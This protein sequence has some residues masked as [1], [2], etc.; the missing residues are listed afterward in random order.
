MTLSFW[1]RLHHSV[2]ACP[3]ALGLVPSLHASAA[4]DPA[5]SADASADWAFKRDDGSSKP[6]PESAPPAERLSFKDGQARAASENRVLLVLVHGSDWNLRGEA[7]MD[8]FWTTAEFVHATGCVVADVDVLETEGSPA[9]ES[10]AIRN[11]GW[12]EKESGL[13]TFPAVLAFGPK[14]TL[15]GTR[16]GQEL[17][18][19]LEGAR[20]ASLKLAQACH[21][22][23][24]LDGELAVA[25]EQG[26]PVRE[27]ALVIERDALPLI[28]KSD[29]QE[30]LKRLDPEDSQGHQVRLTLPS[31][32]SLVQAATQEAQSG[33]P[34][35]AEHRLLGLLSNPAYTP[36]QRAS[37]HL[38]LGSVYRRWEGH[39]AP[40]SE[41]FLAAWRCS[42]ASV[43]GRAGRRLH[44]RHYSGPSLTLGWVERHTASSGEWTV[45][46]LPVELEPGEYT[47]AFRCTRG[48]GPALSAASLRSSSGEI[49]EAWVPEASQGDSQGDSKG[50]EFRFQVDQPIH[51]ASLHIQCTSG[52][53]SRGELTFS[54]VR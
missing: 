12:I 24:Q 42:P 41:Q 4:S 17:P 6:R 27:L 39:G 32:V 23:M 50:G 40:A 45:E 34:Q 53:G 8:G 26:D 21:T 15:L 22:A 11:V 1:G 30:S 20:L 7:F 18:A 43:C 3:L 19:D 16:Q 31:W 48:R 51:A 38:A 35:E 28:R 10:N 14:G 46:D 5:C 13:K 47:L 2:W 29:L 54:R 36:D 37:L 49:I 52:K 9:A 33:K 44:L 25:R